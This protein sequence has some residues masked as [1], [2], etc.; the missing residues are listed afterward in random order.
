MVGGQ[1]GFTDSF[2]ISTWKV[3]FTPDTITGYNKIKNNDFFIKLI[4][5]IGFD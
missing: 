4:L 1:S 3:T 2:V 5:L